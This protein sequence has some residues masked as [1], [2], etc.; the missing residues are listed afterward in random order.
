M[1]LNG[2][3][4]DITDVDLVAE[5]ATC[6]VPESKVRTMLAD[7]KMALAGILFRKKTAYSTLMTYKW[8]NARLPPTYSS[9]A[10]A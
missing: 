4:C 5:A 9:P 10:Y 2:K 1:R 7:V 8:R 6:G 3:G